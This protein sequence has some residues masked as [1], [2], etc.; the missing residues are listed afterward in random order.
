MYKL[1]NVTNSKINSGGNMGDNF[2]VHRKDESYKYNW[3]RW[4]SHRALGD[5]TSGNTGREEN[6]LLSVG[7]GFFSFPIN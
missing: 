3:E 4:N 5:E 7:W 6:C 2:Q 1:Q